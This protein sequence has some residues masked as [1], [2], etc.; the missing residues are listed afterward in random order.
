MLSS[1]I[2]VCYYVVNVVS[3]TVSR[4][5]SSFAVLYIMQSGSGN[6]WIQLEDCGR[7]ILW[8]KIEANHLAARSSLHT[9]KV[10]RPELRYKTSY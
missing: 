8:D 2:H 7:I 9:V 5:G 3:H 4:E 6:S 10:L 1:S